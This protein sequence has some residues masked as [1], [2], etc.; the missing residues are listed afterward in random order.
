MSLT[1]N[2]LSGGY[3]FTCDF[4]P[5]GRPRTDGNPPTPS[6]PKD[7]LD[8]AEPA[9]SAAN[10]TFVEAR[11]NAALLRDFKRET[12]S[13]LFAEPA[14]PA[15]LAH[16]HPPCRETTL[17]SLAGD[18]GAEGAKSNDPPSVKPASNPKTIVACAMSGN[19]CAVATLEPADSS[20]KVSRKHSRLFHLTDTSQ[21]GM[22]GFAGELFQF[23]EPL[24]G[25]VMVSC[26]TRTGS[27]LAGLEDEA[28]IETLLM[29]LPELKVEQV[30]NDVIAKW[31]VSANPPYPE[32]M[33][34]GRNTFAQIR[35]IEAAQY[36]AQGMA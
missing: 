30:D 14:L 36:I 24:R 22:R 15:P 1:S 29:M 23:L 9:I 27:V 2:H 10:L 12:T 26:P 21:A 32:N 3:A 6:A 34:S 28:R 35:A 8:T 7:E 13:I 16:E 4:A 18:A 11:S 33:P 20:W 31:V 5:V 25:A 17:P 19:L